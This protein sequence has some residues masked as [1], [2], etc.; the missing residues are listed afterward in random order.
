MPRLASRRARWSS[1]SRPLSP[2]AE[3]RTCQARR[4]RR[5]PLTPRACRRKSPQ[6]TWNTT[7]LRARVAG[8]SG[9]ST[10]PKH[11]RASS[12]SWRFRMEKCR[13]CRSLARAALRAPNDRSTSA[14][15][16]DKAS[17]PETSQIDRTC[18]I[19]LRQVAQMQQ[20]LIK[21]FGGNA[22]VTKPYTTPPKRPTA[23]INSCMKFPKRC[24]NTIGPIRA[25]R[26]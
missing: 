26:L 24:W 6:A 22:G 8:R 2:D 20:P 13:E 23:T 16:V 17:D 19:S 7:S 4:T 12:A 21:Y 11:T 18:A 14:E 10:T 9:A 15:E 25:P 3:A 1:A 5:Q